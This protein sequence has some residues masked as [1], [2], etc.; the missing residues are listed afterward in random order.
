MAIGSD[1][2]KKPENLFGIFCFLLLLLISFT[3]FCQTE[4]I[5]AL[6]YYHSGCDKVF[7]RNYK[8]AIIEFNWAIKRD[9]AFL[10]AYENRGVAKYYLK[11]FRGAIEDFTKALEINPDDYN[12]FGRRGWARF[13]VQDCRGAIDDFSRAIEGIIDNTQYYN[14]RGQAKYYLQDYQGAIADFNKVIRLWTNERIHRSCA[15]YWRAL[16]KIDLGQRESA[17]LDLSKAWKLG[18]PI[19]F[20]MLDIYCH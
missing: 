7:R 18:F 15:F 11:D 4:D 17:C 5:K 14:G 16:A 2:I 19:A 1:E 3:A 20:Q 8:D 10:Q 6:A 12:T 13:H 9:S